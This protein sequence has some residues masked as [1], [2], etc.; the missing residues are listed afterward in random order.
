M[1][2]VKKAIQENK[3]NYKNL[4][5][6]TIVISALSQFTTSELYEFATN[7]LNYECHLKEFLRKTIINHY[8]KN[9]LN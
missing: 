6:E 1:N 4:S 7:V 5:T 9:D 2:K 3:N 8:L